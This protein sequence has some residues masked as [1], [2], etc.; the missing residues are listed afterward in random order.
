MRLRDW[1]WTHDSS[2]TTEACPPRSVPLEQVLVDHRV[3]HEAG[4][5]SGDGRSRCSRNGLEIPGDW[6]SLNGFYR[7]AQP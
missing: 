5:A 6:I 3:A 4:R 7:E 2:D 1:L